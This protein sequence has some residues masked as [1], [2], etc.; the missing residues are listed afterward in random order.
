[1]SSSLVPELIGSVSRVAQFLWRR[2]FSPD[3]SKA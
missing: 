2:L 3:K 1:L